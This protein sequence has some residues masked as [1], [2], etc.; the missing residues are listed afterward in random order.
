MKIIVE[1]LTKRVK[2][3]FEDND[4]VEMSP[5]QITTEG[6]V[7]C[8][9]NSD[10]SE[11]ISVATVPENPLDYC[12]NTE[13]ISVLNYELF[14]KKDRLYKELSLLRAEMANLITQVQLTN[15]T[16]PQELTDLMPYIRQLN[17]IAKSEIE[18]LTQE[19]IDE[20][21]LRGPKVE[22]AFNILNSYL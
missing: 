11:L 5:L 19:T 2:Y 22:Y 10:N 7:I 4:L 12:Y 21:F 16:E 20:Y 1:K 14:I 9:L 17:V 6:M 18:A 15:E 3:V 8:D 13:F